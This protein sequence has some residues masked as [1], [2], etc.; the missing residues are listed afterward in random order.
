MSRLFLSLACLIAL[1]GCAPATPSAASGLA[2]RRQPELALAQLTQGTELLQEKKYDQAEKCFLQSLD[3]DP[4]SGLAHNNLGSV[5]Y[6]QGRYY[7]AAWQFQY[8]IKLLPHHPEP[9]N[10]L[11]LVLEAA[12]KPEEAISQYQQAVALE[13]DNPDLLGNLARAHIRRGDQ[14][15]QTRKLLL[16]LAGKEERP[17]WRQWVQRELATGHWLSHSEPAK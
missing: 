1:G 6:H 14:D 7:E 11:G 17:E 10:N 15:E 4:F 8:A 2:P 12:S 3:A 9:H 5:Y 16:E 13:P